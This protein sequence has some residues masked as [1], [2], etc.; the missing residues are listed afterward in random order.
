MSLKHIKLYSDP[1]VPAVLATEGKELNPWVGQFVGVGVTG[2]LQRDL[3][4]RWGVGVPVGGCRELALCTPLAR[5]VLCSS[6]FWCDLWELQLTGHTSPSWSAL[7]TP[8]HILVG[9]RNS[10]FLFELIRTKKKE[11]EKKKEFSHWDLGKGRGGGTLTWSSEAALSQAERPRHLLL[12]QEA[13]PWGVQPGVHPESRFLVVRCL[14]FAGMGRERGFRRR[15]EEEGVF[16]PEMRA[17]L[18]KS[19]QGKVKWP[20]ALGNVTHEVTF[21]VSRS[22]R[23]SSFVERAFRAF[24]H[25]DLSPLMCSAPRFT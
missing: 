25:A 2:V 9:L 18:A 6:G 16:L 7:L 17:R 8:C 23:S 4:E 14:F 12:P 20:W 1:H 24:C 15:K 19:C 21:D 10:L 13:S 11:K 3:W 22:L 5:L